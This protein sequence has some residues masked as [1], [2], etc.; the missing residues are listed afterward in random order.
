MCGSD[1]YEVTRRPENPLDNSG[2]LRASDWF[3]PQFRKLDSIDFTQNTPKAAKLQI[4][5]LALINAT[6][7]LD[8]IDFTSPKHFGTS[9]A[10]RSLQNTCVI[11]AQTNWSIDFISP[12]HPGSTEINQSPNLSNYRERKR[13]GVSA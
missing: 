2:T 11:N 10:N 12:K 7:K 13:L 8:S 4:S 9:E 5:K 1:H 3:W 6:E